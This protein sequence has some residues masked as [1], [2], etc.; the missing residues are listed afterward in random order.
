MSCSQLKWLEALDAFIHT[1]RAG[2]FIFEDIRRAVFDAD[3]ELASV[4]NMDS[5]ITKMFLESF[6]E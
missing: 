4:E 1:K 2:N 6:S 5:S 3:P